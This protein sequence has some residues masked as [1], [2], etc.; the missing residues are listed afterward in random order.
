MADQITGKPLQFVPL[1]SEI[2]LPFYSA[3]FSMKLETDMLN[4]SARSITAAYEARV[5][6]PEDSCKVQV[7]GNSLSSQYVAPRGAGRADGTLRNTNTWEDF[8]NLDRSALL[9]HSA[10]QIWDAIK[11]GT[12]YSVPSMLSS[13]N[14]ISYADLKK[15]NYT[16]WFAFP[17]LHSS[18]IHAAEIAHITPDESTALVES[19]DGWQYRVKDTRQH[20]FF[21]AKKVLRSALQEDDDDAT[22]IATENKSTTEFEDEHTLPYVWVVDSLGRFEHGFF[23]GVADEDRFVGFLD[24]STY[25]RNPGWQLRNLLVLVQRR[26]KMN[27]VNILCYRD[28]H[29]H[30]DAAR[31]IIMKLQAVDAPT[32]SLT[33]AEIP[34]VTGWEKNGAS[35][36]YKRVSLAAYMDPMRMA[37]QSVDLNLK[38]M[39]WRLAP[40]LI[41]ENI[42]RQKCLLLG[43]G[44]LGSYVARNLMA[45]GIR[46]IT[47]VDYGKVSFSNP[48]RQPLFMFKDCLDGGSPKAATAAAALKEIYPGVT[49]VGHQ[50]A[51]PM[52]GHAVTDT[53]KTKADYDKLKSL[54]EEHDVIFLLMDTRESRW[55]PT[56]MGK[57]AGKIVLNAALGFDSYVIMRH[58]TE[59]DETTEKGDSQKPL[60]CYFCNDVVAPADSMRDQTLDQQCTVTRPG[61]APIA[62]AMIVEL[63]ASLLQHPLQNKAPAPKTTGLHAERDPPDHPLGTVPH[64]VRGFVSSF[65]NVVLRG[66]AYPNCS[67]CSPVILKAFREA[68]W[69]FVERALRE[70]DYVAELSGL[71]ELQR[72]AE[73]MA[74][75]VEWDSEGGSAGGSGGLSD[76]EG[77]LI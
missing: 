43:A 72:R 49:S 10:K 7:V 44:T 65:Q 28:V 27:K 46:H 58:G 5:S 9:K 37:D 14:L 13:F 66:E 42:S 36:K 34:K 52:L 31:S 67:A 60:G 33:T 61:V 2:E 15:F 70:K 41:L 29:S 39:K 54:I 51:V 47:F 16:Y 32:E 69:G 35:F 12:I 71:A 22:S 64:Q 24:S 62:S 21:V 19:V 17:A 76:G 20:G 6:R 45:W 1:S 59:A 18:W 77:E 8:K 48:V 53:E 3:L 11:D 38:L 74:A 57:A 30:R 26:F 63:L 56:V 50:L 68:G 55:L 73:Q 23:D 25:A 75:D 4:D 40:N